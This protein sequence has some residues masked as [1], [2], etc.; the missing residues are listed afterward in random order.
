LIRRIVQRELVNDPAKAL[1]RLK[2][3]A[4]SST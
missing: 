4:E 1:A 3:Q 2:T